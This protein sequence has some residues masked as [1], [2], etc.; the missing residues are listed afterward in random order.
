MFQSPFAMID[1]SLGEWMGD[2]GLVAVMTR[3]RIASD[4][5][6]LHKLNGKLC[7]TRVHLAETVNTHLTRPGKACA[8]LSEKSPDHYRSTTAV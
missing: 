3:W 4:L 8:R 5:H 1:I 2:W 7:T 6:K